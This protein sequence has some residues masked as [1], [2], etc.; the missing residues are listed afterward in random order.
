VAVVGVS[1][2][3]GQ[4]GAEIF[5]NLLTGFRGRVVPVNPSTSEIAGVRAY[6]R[7]TDVPAPVDLAVVA[8]PAPAVESVLGDC[9]AARVPATVVTSAGFGETGEAGRAC[10]ARMRDTARRAGMRL[11]GP[12][13]LGLVN[14]DPAVHL[15]ASFSPVF[16]PAGSIAFSSQSGAL[17]LAILE[18]AAKRHLGI[19][20]FVSVGNK[21]DVSSNDLLEYWET[22]P[23]TAV[24]LLYLESFGNPKRFR[25][26]ARRVST[27]KPI[28]AVKAGRS[29]SGARAASSHTGALATSDAIVDALFRDAGVIRVDTVEELFDIAALLAHQ[30]LPAGPRVA[31]LTNAGGRSRCCSRTKGSTAC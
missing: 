27:T 7:V 30:P 4:V 5:H 14:T 22:D 2:R 11:I 20:T 19:S 25:E 21:A 24:V 12:N 3:R 8:V 28:V 13:C 16:P 29:C 10:E 26:I 15:N 23:R 1:R 9:L 31:I 18:Y 17:G 6:A